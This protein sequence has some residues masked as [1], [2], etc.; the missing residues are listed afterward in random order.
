MIGFKFC[1]SLWR[2]PSFWPWRRSLLAGPCA[3]GVGIPSHL[4]I[5]SGCLGLSDL[6]LTEEGG[7]G[8][9]GGGLVGL[10]GLVHEVVGG[11]VQGAGVRGGGGGLF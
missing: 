8:G 2:R 10:G 4:L 6:N 3:G 9:G 11:L 5:S 7:W 1:V